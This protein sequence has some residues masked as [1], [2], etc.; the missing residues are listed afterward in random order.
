MIL[1]NLKKTCWAKHCM[2]NLA[3]KGNWNTFGWFVKHNFQPKSLYGA[4]G[5][6]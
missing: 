6:R 5:H 2:N 3:K 4:L 1:D